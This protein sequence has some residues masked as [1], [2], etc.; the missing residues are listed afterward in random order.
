[1]GTSDR[2]AAWLRITAST[3]WSW[4]RIMGTLIASAIYITPSRRARRGP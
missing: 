1:M 4:V 2:V 3:A